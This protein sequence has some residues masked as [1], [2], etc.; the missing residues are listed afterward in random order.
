MSRH[1]S[2]IN[3]CGAYSAFEARILLKCQNVGHTY[4]MRVKCWFA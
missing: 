2:L 4:A 1:V 3:A